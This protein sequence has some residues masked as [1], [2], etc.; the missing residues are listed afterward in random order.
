MHMS[1]G[2]FGVLVP[3][4]VSLPAWPGTAGR[5]TRT[6]H[7][8]WLAR[9]A[10]NASHR[11]QKG[12]GCS[13]TRGTY[14]VMMRERAELVRGVQTGEVSGVGLQHERNKA[15][16]GCPQGHAPNSAWQVSTC[17]TGSLYLARPHC[18]IST[19]VHLQL[20]SLPHSPL[21]ALG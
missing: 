18:H 17:N 15:V 8:Y 16:G 20:R 9:P 14:R 11:R 13:V 3:C 2:R 19:H 5:S 10:M 1:A 7:I 21:G 12:G 6:V 4:N